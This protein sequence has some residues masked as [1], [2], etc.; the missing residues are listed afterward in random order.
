MFSDCSAPIADVETMLAELARNIAGQADNLAEILSL[1]Q[2]I[3]DEEDAGSLAKTG[4]QILRLVDPFLES[5]VPPQVRK[6]QETK[7]DARKLEFQISSCAGSSSSQM[8]ISLSGMASQL[9]TIAAS[10]A[11]QARAS[12]LHQTATSLQIAA[13]ALSTLQQS[14][15]GFYG[16]VSARQN[17]KM[18]HLWRLW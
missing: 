6:T 11:D 17:S 18:H 1:G 8:L 3:K 7:H 5:L 16:A 13:W 12:D 9:D 4:A 15:H 2:S 14:V 10:E